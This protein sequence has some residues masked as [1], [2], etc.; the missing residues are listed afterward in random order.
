MPVRVAII[1]TSRNNRCWQGCGEI[2]ML[3]SCRQE[4]KL[5]QPLWKTLWWFLKGLEP[6][7]PFDQTIS[8]LGLYSKEY[9]LFYYKGTCAC[10]FIA[11]L[12]TI[13]KSWNQPKCPLKIDCVKK[14]WY[15]YTMEYCAAK[16]RNEIISF[17]RTWMKLE[18]IIHS[19]LTQ[20]QNAKC[21][22]L[23]LIRGS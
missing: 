18:A 5:A 15:I 23:S 13:A 14:M 6:E 21:C 9:K 16:K 17:A 19:K 11:A 4:C 8:L 3:L 12:F 2:G 1:K 7:I 22:M 10:I 20:E